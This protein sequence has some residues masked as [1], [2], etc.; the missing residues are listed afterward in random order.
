[1]FTTN[2]LA[3]RYGAPKYAGLRMDKADF[4]RWESDDN[5]VYEYNDGILEPTTGIRQDENYLFTNLEDAF[6][7]SAAFQK[8]ACL[9]AGMDFWV[10]DRQMRRADVSYFTTDQ[11]RQMT[12]G[13][14]VIPNFVVEF[15]SQTDNELVS[16]TKRHE[17]FDAG[18]QVVWWVYPAF[19]EV[20]V[21]TSPK[22]VIIG[23]NDDVLS[24]APVLPDFQ[25]TVA[26]LFRR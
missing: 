22:A 7:R 17:Y 5:Y 14:R 13:L 20:Y 21:Y 19:E 24:V 11:I 9:R 1:M 8:G 3:D 12:T 6:F 4:L 25:L 15:A 10:T 2:L 18:V 16:I 23:T 26:E